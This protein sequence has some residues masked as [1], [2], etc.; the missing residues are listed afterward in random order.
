[1]VPARPTRLVLT[2]TGMSRSFP[3]I[4]PITDH[5]LLSSPY[6]YLPIALVDD[7]SD[8]RAIVTFISVFGRKT[9]QAENYS[10]TSANVS[11][12]IVWDENTMHEYLEN[13]KKVRSS[14]PKI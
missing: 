10:Y 5:V 1:L 8:N 7:S 12:A 4:S 3:V 6:S 2:S 14:G 11:K 13:P 9:G